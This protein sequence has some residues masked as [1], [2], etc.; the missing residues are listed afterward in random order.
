MSEL[1]TTIV[2]RSILIV[3]MIRYTKLSRAACLGE[4]QQHAAAITTDRTPSA[5]I[6]CTEL[7]WVKNTTSRKR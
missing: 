3:A 5:R 4:S 1:L 7:C 6:E 2:N